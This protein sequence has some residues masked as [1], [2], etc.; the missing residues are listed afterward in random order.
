[1]INLSILTPRSAVL[2]LP[3]KLRL[4]GLIE[5]EDD[6][7]LLLR[8]LNWA[9]TAPTEQQLA[10]GTAAT[11]C[12][13]EL[14]DT[15]GTVPSI[16]VFIT[17]I[18]QDALL[19][20]FARADN[21]PSVKRYLKAL[22]SQPALND[23]QQSQNTKL[24]QTQDLL[25]SFESLGLSTLD[26]MF[27]LFIQRLGTYL[28]DESTTPGRSSIAL[29]EALR[30]LQ[31]HQRAIG[32]NF[33]TRI[34][35]RCSDLTP[36]RQ[37]R[38]QQSDS[39]IAWQSLH[40][41]NLDE[42]EES[43]ALDRMINTGSQAQ[44]L[45][46]ECLVIRLATA[47]GVDP[48]ELRLPF[49][50]TELCS[51]LQQALQEH[52]IEHPATVYVYDYFVGQFLSQ[53]DQLY[54]PLNQLLIDAGLCPGLEQDIKT[55]GSQLQRPA[56]TSA[57]RPKRKKISPEPAPDQQT[58]AQQQAPNK[59]STVA[60]L[61][62][63]MLYRSVIDA[64]NFSRHHS[65]APSS[66]ESRP[67]Q[68]ADT[69]TLVNALALLQE[70]DEARKLIEQSGSLRDYLKQH[71]ESIS[72]LEGITALNTDSMN[73]LDLVDNLFQTIHSQREL[74]AELQPAI[75]E[76]QLPLARL[77][78]LEPGFFFDQ[79]HP[80]RELVD[81]LSQLASADNFPNRILEE[82]L[83]SII[84]EIVTGYER[85]SAVFNSALEQ[86]NKLIA[87]RNSAHIRN[88]ERVVKT[89]E[90]QERLRQAR[91]EVDRAIVA[92]LP[93]P[94]PPKILLELIDKGWRD[95]L[96]LIYIKEG[97][98][99]D[100]WQ[101]QMRTLELLGEWLTEQQNEFNSVQRALEAAPFIDLLAQQIAVVRPAN[102]EIEAVFDEL[103]RVLSGEQAVLNSELNSESLINA[104]E[105]SNI[106]QRLQ[107]THRLRRWIE[108]VN[109]LNLGAWLSYRD[110]HGE[111]RRMQLAWINADRDRF[112]FV[113][114]HGQKVTELNAVQL[115]R[116]LSHGAKPPSQ[117][118]NMP[119]VD[120]SMYGTLEQVQQTLSFARHRDKVTRLLNRESFI[121]QLNK[122]LRHAQ[123]RSSQHAVLY[124]NIDQFNLVNEIYDRVS[125]DQVLAEFAELLSQLHDKKFSSAHLGE[126]NF[127]ILLA[128]HTLS[129]ALAVAE[130]IRSDIHANNFDIEQEPVQLSVSIGVAALRHFSPDADSVI[131][132]AEQ[133][134]QAAKQGGGN[135][136]QQHIAAA[137]SITRHKQD[138]R[139]TRQNLEQALT[140]ERFVLR[141]QPIVQNAVASQQPSSQHF[142]LLLG[143]R[144]TDGSL[145]SPKQFIK[146]AERHGYMSLVDR[147]VIREAFQWISQLMDAQKVVPNLSINLSGTSI[148]DDAFME[149]L[150]EQISEFG[151]GTSRLCFEVTE[152][153]TMTNLVKSADFIRAFRN[154]GCKF[155]LDNFGTGLSSHNYL[156]ELSVDYV[157]I[158]GAFI[159]G[160]NDNPND[161]TMARSI[162]DLA[163]FL[164][165]ETIAESVENERTIARLHEI[166]VDYLQGWGIGHPE[167]LTDIV[168]QLQSLQ[169]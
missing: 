131:E 107:R 98:T 16:P 153:A 53:L 47:I 31:Y 74:S 81:K 82:K 142:E 159:T 89:Q 49:H 15:R 111:R 24:R 148:T 21:S 110:R 57:A 150:F 20:T 86:V 137:N 62:P 22:S 46:L 76:L 147:W 66:H 72:G 92:A 164:G 85:D 132:A 19:L 163:H 87:Q 118:E 23:G 77:A 157:K 151:V 7:Q 3:D 96:V 40:L 59:P 129:E 35:Q 80:A 17:E 169:K 30:L 8:D 120:Q 52:D 154:I 34:Q 161:Y 121:E 119:L 138:R 63:E 56:A 94:Q 2:E 158:D 43:L 91:V 60:S 71:S 113:N 112:M 115:A 106:Q 38:Y 64:L 25:A 126:D 37:Q 125:G 103:R 9:N 55:H 6:N 84:A 116:Q 29:R 45:T 61:S 18:T 99:S 167:P 44:E 58:E 39:E 26:Q 83:S 152:A 93:R 156:R 139:K 67:E 130:S 146:S 108:R 162:N 48:L 122:A 10:L 168:G 143:M 36:A 51:S 105:S 134:M 114:E 104:Q 13:P 145:S 88:V 135:Q 149:Y 90:G 28:F 27:R 102:I 117:A 141:A 54:R 70:N 160:I 11:L 165:Q 32:D 123:R 166:G 140:T 78:L 33:I 1:M 155:S 68:L 5:L 133:A 65:E 144:E 69:A 14:T 79:Q 128:D 42:F 100:S 95:A 50:V 109:Q 73:Q 4:S 12:I 97:P 41:V 136:V 124:L 75:A 127:G 101:E